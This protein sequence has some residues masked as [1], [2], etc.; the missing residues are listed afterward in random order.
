LIKFGTTR[1]LTT[2]LAFGELFEKD[3]VRGERFDFGL[4]LVQ[5]DAKLFEI[6]KLLGLCKFL[7]AV[8]KF[9]A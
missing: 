1:R 7:A 3:V 4:E 6:I 9:V 2:L 8:Q 5:V